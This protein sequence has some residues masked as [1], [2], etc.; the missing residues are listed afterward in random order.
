MRQIKLT[1]IT[2]AE[3]DILHEMMHRYF[4]E[5]NSYE[6]HPEDIDIYFDLYWPALFEDIEYRELLWITY[7]NK[8]VGFTVIRIL[9]DWPDS[10]KTIASIAE[11]YIEPTS[12]RSGIGTTAISL[13]L[14]DHRERGTA[15]VEAYILVNNEPATKFWKNL[16]FQVQYLQTGRKP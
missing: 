15:L 3:Y 12:R 9:P 6:S 13:L 14:D 1:P 16:G 7:N 5:I 2:D 10:K 11:F 8:N 4:L